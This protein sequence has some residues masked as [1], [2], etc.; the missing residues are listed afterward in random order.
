MA[1]ALEHF[2]SSKR[3]SGEHPGLGYEPRDINKYGAVEVISRRV[4]KGAS[5]FSSVPSEHTYEAIVCRY[6][7]EFPEDVVAI[8]KTRLSTFQTQESTFDQD[9]WQER[10][11]ALLLGSPEN[12]NGAHG[13]VAPETKEVTS[14]QFK[15]DPTVAAYIHHIANGTCESCRQKAPFVKA[16]G[17]PFLEIHHV[18]PLSQ[19]GA[20]KECNVV[21]VCP[22]CHRAL[23]LAEDAKNRTNMLY[24]SIERLSQRTNSND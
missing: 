5:G 14:R 18:V 1:A 9:E 24:V 13:S 10:T 15:R 7:G 11:D 22:N 17:L 4:Q 3:A 8:A 16:N 12:L 23:H 6:A 2:Q 20:D 21:A 19:G